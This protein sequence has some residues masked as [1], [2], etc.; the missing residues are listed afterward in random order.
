LLLFLPCYIV[1][2]TTPSPSLTSF[3]V[4]L[5]TSEKSQLPLKGTRQNPSFPLEAPLLN[6]A[7]LLQSFFIPE[8]WRS[9]PSDRLAVESDN[10]PPVRARLQNHRRSD[11]GEPQCLITS[12]HTLQPRRMFHST[13][14]LRNSLYARPLLATRG[15]PAS[16]LPD[17][18]CLLKRLSYLFFS[19][20][21][22]DSTKPPSSCPNIFLR[23]ELAIETPFFSFPFP[24]LK[25]CCF[26]FSSVSPLHWGPLIILGW[27]FELFLHQSP[28]IF[29]PP[30]CLKE[31]AFRH[32]AVPTKEVDRKPFPAV[33]SYSPI[34]LVSLTSLVRTKSIFP[35]PLACRVFF[36][37]LFFPGL[38]LT[39]KDSSDCPIMSPVP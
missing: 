25:I 26:I 21:S 17:F 23:L 8:Y 11:Q 14:F 28:P 36:L 16:P 39:S 29:H 2:F 15:L 37:S 31:M 18:Y 4:L 38:A 32:W 20:D 19:F 7:T 12:V 9:K 34:P 33:S 3:F 22:P 13:F 27:L 5:S 30:P 10:P 24:I 1:V 6:Y 35:Y